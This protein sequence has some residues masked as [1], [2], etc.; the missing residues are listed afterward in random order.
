MTILSRRSTQCC[1]QLKPVLKLYYCTVL[2]WFDR[3]TVVRSNTVRSRTFTRTVPYSVLGRVKIRYSNTVGR[4]KAD[5][6]KERL[7]RLTRLD[8]T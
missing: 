6:I 5:A 4:E 2:Y 7:T 8:N 3:V 1:D